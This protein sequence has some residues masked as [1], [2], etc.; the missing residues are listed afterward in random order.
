MSRI[1][2]AIS[3]HAAQRP[4]HAALIWPGGRISYARLQELVEELTWR[5][6]RSGIGRLALHLANGP[7][8][9]IWDLAALRAEV[10]LIPLPPF[11]APG[12][13]LHCLRDSGAHALVTD[14]PAELEQLLEGQIGVTGRAEWQIDRQSFACLSLQTGPHADLPDGVSKISYTSGTTGEPKGVL[15]AADA[16]ERVAISLSEAANATSLD[17]HLTTL[18]LAILLE[19]IGA[20]HVPLLAGASTILP[21]VEQTGLRGATGID[22]RILAGALAGQAA[23]SAIL[24]PQSLQ[25]LVEALEA[26]APCPGSLRFVAVGGAPTSPQLLERATRMGLPVFEGYGL[27]ECASV[28]TLNTAQAQRPGSVGRP[29]PHVRLRIAGD[30]EVLVA[31]NPF[32]GYLGQP[33]SMPGEWFRTGDIGHL[34]ADGFLHLQGRS[35]NLFITAFGRNV[36]PEWVERE[37]TLQSGIAQAV[38]FGEGRPWNSAVI[39]PRAGQDA[40]AVEASLASANAL[41][42]DYARVQRWIP[43][44]TPF[45]PN[46]GLLTGT[47]R[48]RRN[49]LWARY[50][51]PI[52]HLYQEIPLS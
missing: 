9:A 30:G 40:R 52:E 17:R 45:T 16:I 15:L 51:E 47:G 2:Q 4:E 1:W 26:G 27:S 22:G 49:E 6:R 18:P 20:I 39:V 28:V 13:I 21:P 50:R 3:R 42:P 5:L 8:W 12:Q 48:L 43:A 23:T 34:D 38:V 7:H 35:R 46:N 11:F 36:S 10:T 31:G 24:M 33:G 41:L 44:A 19:N 14:Q 37:L 25:A 32:L 29:L